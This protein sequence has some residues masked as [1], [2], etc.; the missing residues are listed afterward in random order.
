[1]LHGYSGAFNFLVDKK[2]ITVRATE[3]E[4]EKALEHLNHLCAGVQ[5]FLRKH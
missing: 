1:M 2:E 4:E 5:W 3:P